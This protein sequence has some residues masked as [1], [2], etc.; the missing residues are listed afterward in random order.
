MPCEIVVIIPADIAKSMIRDEIKLK[1]NRS[2]MNK[3]ID[4]SKMI[5]VAGLVNSGLTS[6][7]G[8]I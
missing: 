1:I 6:L 4:V 3:T 8:G 7:I 5:K 2:V